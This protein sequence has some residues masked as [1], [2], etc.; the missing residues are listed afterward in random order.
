MS[1]GRRRHDREPRIGFE[2]L[3][4][5]PDRVSNLAI[6]VHK[7]AIAALKGHQRDCTCRPGMKWA[8]PLSAGRQPEWWSA[9][10]GPYRHRA[11]GYF[12]VN[13][14][15]GIGKLVL[16]GSDGARPLDAGQGM[17]CCSTEWPSLSRPAQLGPAKPLEGD[18]FT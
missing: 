7:N 5:A 9:D 13:N 17:V 14:N 10:A 2:P 16:N 8:I 1:D 6:E 4:D 3:S 12:W 11:S 18:L 15:G